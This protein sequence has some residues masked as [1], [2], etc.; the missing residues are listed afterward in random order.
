MGTR[1]PDTVLI[2]G[3]T[4]LPFADKAALREAV[5]RAKHLQPT[6]IIQIGDLYDNFAFSRFYKDLNKTHPAVELSEGEGQAR[7]LWADLKRAAPHSKCY[8]LNGN[9]DS[10]RL[11]KLVLQSQPE[12]YSIVAEFMERRMS[13]EGVH[14]THDYR[15]FLKLSINGR[16]TTFCHG[17]LSSTP[18]H[19]S[20][21]KTD[22]V[23]GHLHRPEIYYSREF[24]RGLTN[25]A[26]N[27]GYL[28]AA[29]SH[30]FSYTASIK[31][32]WATAIGIID[33]DGPRVVTL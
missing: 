23:L 26:M 3:D 20:F 8:Q 31:K 16:D 24:G 29:E 5:Y 7:K 21:F 30:V 17:F 13:F 14:T 11:K 32:N 1:K 10:E 28:G 4:H 18:K 19:L 2:L 22:T 27:V 15:S 6:H 9:H 33:R 12:V 25:Y